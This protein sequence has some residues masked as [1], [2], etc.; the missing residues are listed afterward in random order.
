MV[1]VVML[2]GIPASGKSSFASRLVHSNFELIN[3]ISPDIIRSQLYGSSHIQGNWQEIYAQIQLQ[4][5]EAYE[6]QKSVIYDA[7]NYLGS[8]RREII[9]LS[10]N[11]GFSRVTGIWLNVPLWLCL[12]RNEKRPNPVPESIISEMYKSLMQRSPSLSEGFDSLLIKEEGGL[13]D[14]LL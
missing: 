10:K 7:T 1:K 9:T 4:F 5:Q 3:V 8:Y 6:A 12:D 14:T 13:D 11:L 2:I